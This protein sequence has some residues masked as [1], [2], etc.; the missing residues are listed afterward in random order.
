MQVMQVAL[1]YGI[2]TAPYDGK[3]TIDILESGFD[4]LMGMY[5]AR[6][7]YTKRNYK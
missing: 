3:I 4:T 6:L 7:K 5:I 1:L 2:I